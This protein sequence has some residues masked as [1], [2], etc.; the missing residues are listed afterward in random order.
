MEY[1]AFA[2]EG[3]TSSLEDFE[4]SSCNQ[5]DVDIVAVNGSGDIEAA[6]R[7]SSGREC[8]RRTG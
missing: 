6:T 7:R 4:T 1:H 2:R 8:A 5:S 3:I